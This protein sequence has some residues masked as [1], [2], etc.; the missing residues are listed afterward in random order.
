M[1]PS[2]ALQPGRTNHPSFALMCGS[3]S[4]NKVGAEGAKS[5]ADV[6]QTNDSLTSLDLSKNFLCGMYWTGSEWSG[7]FNSGGICEL[8]RSLHGSSVASLGLTNN[9]MCGINGHDHGTYTA[10]LLYTS[11]SKGDGLLTKITS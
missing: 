5:L 3:R 7:S 6:W 1:G 8:I 11:P 10:G 9:Q 2:C 4:D